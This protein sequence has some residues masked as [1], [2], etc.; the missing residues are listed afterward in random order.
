VL[1]EDKA[2]GR[3]PVSDLLFR[4]RSGQLKV[5]KGDRAKLTSL[6]AEALMD[7]DEIWIGVGQKADPVDREQEELVVDRR[8]IRADPSNGLLIVFEI[9]EKWWEAITAYN[10][11]T[12]SGKPDL[13]TLDRRRGGKLLYKRP[14]K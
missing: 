6:L 2:G 9:G 3:V 11:T 7:P 14:K 12:K 4:N 1:F 5:M 13:K 10:T 8:Y